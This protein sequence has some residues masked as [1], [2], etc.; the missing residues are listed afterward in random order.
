MILEKNGYQVSLAANGAEALQKAEDDL[1]D[2]IILDVVMP[3]K[4]GWEVCKTLKSQDRTKHIPIVI[5]TVLSIAIGDESSRKYAKEAGA[6]GYLPKPFNTKQ[7]LAIVKKHLE[8]R[9]MA[10]T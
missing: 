9:T 10:P 8:Q 3:A 6:N 4:S 2:L 7:L 5:F 1:P